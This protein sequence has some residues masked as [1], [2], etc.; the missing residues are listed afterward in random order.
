MKQS[1]YCDFCYVWAAYKTGNAPS[2]GGDRN[3]KMATNVPH[4]GGG[5][6][7]K[8]QKNAPSYGGEKV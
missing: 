6:G 3:R 7:C 2:Y 4:P 5:Q 1:M 8:K